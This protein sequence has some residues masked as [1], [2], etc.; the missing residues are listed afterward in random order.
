MSHITTYSTDLQLNPVKGERAAK[1]DKS[2]QLFQ[3]ALEIVAEEYGGYVSDRIANYYGQQRDCTFSLVVPQF[4]YGLGIDV[5]KNTGEVSFVY[6][7]YGV[8]E[9]V[10]EDLK[11]RIIQTF[12]T[13][14]VSQTL[15]DLNYEVEYEENV[16][17]EERKRQVTVRGVM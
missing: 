14:A 10:I 6:D 17:E 7:S 3:E 4:R 11:D 15:R 1:N 9:Q 2:W 8:R 12:T 13:L 5:D 16:K